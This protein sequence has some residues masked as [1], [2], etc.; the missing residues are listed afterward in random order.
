MKDLIS[1]V[2]RGD[3]S[4]KS[5]A[6]TI[7]GPLVIAIGA[8]IQAFQLFRAIP[9]LFEVILSSIQGNVK[10][11]S[12]SLLE[13]LEIGKQAAQLNPLAGGLTVPL[14]DNMIK[15]IKEVVKEKGIEI[16]TTDEEIGS[17][18]ELMGKLRELPGEYQPIIDAIMNTGKV[19]EGGTELQS[20]FADS[21]RLAGGVGRQQWAKM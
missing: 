8:A 17:W 4:I 12:E 15:K 3:T 6:L 20:R 19:T 1:W 14:Y 18:D 21:A 2:G 7:V 16:K 5:L 13:L 10:K 11:A 9:K